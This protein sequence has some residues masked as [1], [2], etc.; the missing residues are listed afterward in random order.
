M[1]RLL[2]LA[3]ILLASPAMAGSNEC[4]GAIALNDKWLAIIDIDGQ[5]TCQ[6]KRNSPAAK[7]ILATCPQYSHCLIELPLPPSGDVSDLP[8]TQTITKILSVERL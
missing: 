4:D 5:T 6:A 7:R 3:F 8:P 2:A 1:K